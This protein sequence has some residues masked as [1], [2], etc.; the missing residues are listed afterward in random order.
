MAPEPQLDDFGA[1]AIKAPRVNIFARPAPANGAP[2]STAAI[3]SGAFD[4]SAACRQ[5]PI[6]DTPEDARPTSRG[7]TRTTG[8]AALAAV[9]AAVVVI[10]TSSQHH[11]TAVPTHPAGP[12]VARPTLP[13]VAHRNG[14]PHQRAPRRPP[15]SRAHSM[16]IP[17]VQRV[18]PRARPHQASIAPPAPPAPAPPAPVAPRVAP[19]TPSTPVLTRPTPARVPKGA[20]PEFM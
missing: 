17:R 13:S 16:R 20:P 4:A 3:S 7:W 6:G 19:R 18:K 12:T 5:E 10:A 1:L 14:A 15:R 9:C 2:E 8:I 11:P